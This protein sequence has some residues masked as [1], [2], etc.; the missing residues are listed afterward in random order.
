[1]ELYH[2]EASYALLYKEKYMQIS[3]MIVHT[4]QSTIGAGG[5]AS[6]LLDNKGLD[7]MWRSG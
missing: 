5:I 6:R 2:N 1:M 3:A 4:Y 7:G